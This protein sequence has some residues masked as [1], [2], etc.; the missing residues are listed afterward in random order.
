[1]NSTSQAPVSAIDIDHKLHED[2]RRRVA[3]YG[4]QTQ[5][6][7]PVLSVL[8]RTFA[9]QL[10]TFY[11]D[12]D[13][14]RLALLD[15]LIAGLG[16]QRRSARPAQTTVRF[17]VKSGSQ[18]IEAGTALCGNT[19]S[20][21]RLAFRTDLDVAV[22]PAH[23]AFIAAYEKGAIQLAAPASLDEKFQA[24]RPVLDP[25]AVNLGPNPALYFAVENLS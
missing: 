25:I 2:F 11:A 1:M 3:E 8:F 13:R 15:E 10:E 14:I 18:L 6:V 9:Q 7:D 5:T 20:G 22:S 23:V 12:T 21:E 4:I 16:I 19:A 24:A 17:V